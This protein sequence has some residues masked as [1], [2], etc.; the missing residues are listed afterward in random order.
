[1]HFK[2]PPSAAESRTILQSQACRANLP[3]TI[4]NRAALRRSG[5]ARG[6]F[7][8]GPN[9]APLEF[10]EEREDGMS[11]RPPVECNRFLHDQAIEM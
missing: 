6:V 8:L 9:P 2:G 7:Y 1:M 11:A 5:T 3:T 4:A 10:F